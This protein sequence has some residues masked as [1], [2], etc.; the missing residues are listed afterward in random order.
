MLDDDGYKMNTI[1]VFGH[2]FVE[3]NPSKSVGLGQV[4]ES[5]GCKECRYLTFKMRKPLMACLDSS[6]YV[7]CTTKIKSYAFSYISVMG[8]QTQN[9]PVYS[10]LMDLQKE[11]SLEV[12]SKFFSGEFTEAFEIISEQP[13]II[14]KIKNAFDKLS[15]LLDSKAALIKPI[16]LA[17]C[18]KNK[19]LGDWIMM[20]R[21]ISLD[22][23]SIKKEQI[24]FLGD[25]ISSNREK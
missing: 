17:I 8:V 2:N 23:K 7:G 18:Q 15:I 19:D 20:N 12:L 13:Q 1:T 3:N 25:I 9:V 14:D 22:E 5:I 4:I 21:L 6:L 10:Y 24:K 16:F 11:N